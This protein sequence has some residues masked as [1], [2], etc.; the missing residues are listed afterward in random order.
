MII[1]PE[2]VQPLAL[3]GAFLATGGGGDTMIGEITTKNALERFGA[4]ELLSAEALDD[5]A[6]VVA[7]GAAGSPTIMQEKP[8]N[9][10]EALWALAALE[11]HLGRKADA[12]IAFEAGGMN[13]LLPFCAAAERNLPVVDADGMG[14]AF[15]E[16][17]MESFSIYGVSATPL[18][19]AAELG[20]T[21]ILDNIKNAETAEQIV[22]NFSVA[23]GGGQ[24]VSAEHVMSGETVKRVSI[25]GTLSLCLEIGRLLIANANNL[26]RFIGE[27]TKLL[28]PTH[29]GDVRKLFQ[30]KVVDVSRRVEGG[31]DF[32]TLHLEP[33]DQGA[34]AMTI[35]IKN[36]YLIAIQN[37]RPVALTPDL[38]CILD[39]E[40]GR[41]IT[42]ETIRYGQRVTV[43][44]IGAP[45]RMRTAKALTVV[46]PRNFG[47]DFDYTPI[48]SIP[49]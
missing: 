12:L 11:T 5:D 30:G 25:L 32:G 43:I 42:A 35:S 33:F 39:N 14:R 38:I 27:L 13:A 2:H 18:A 19:A 15:P 1:H 4:V 24:C 9:G 8:S 26:D 40:T 46:S 49:V 44:G 7:L 41:P 29:Y 6:L 17:Q 37:D 31:Y 20:D 34:G 10:R 36:E 48:E 21:L 23:A 3:G 22:R 47:F 28:V 45:A 16:L